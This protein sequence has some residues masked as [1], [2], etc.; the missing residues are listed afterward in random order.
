MLYKSD[1]RFLEFNARYSKL[2]P[3]CKDFYHF[4]KTEAFKPFS[5]KTILILKVALQFQCFLTSK[6]TKNVF[7]NQ[8]FQG[9][10]YFSFT[11]KFWVETLD[12]GGNGD[13]QHLLYASKSSKNNDIH[14]Q[15][16]LKSFTKGHRPSNFPSES[17]SSF[18]L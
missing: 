15:K 6:H 2:F 9:S 12:K 10:M 4:A 11:S 3:F 1:D 16:G 8:N 5:Q 17:Y 14:L 7:M 13:M 18:I